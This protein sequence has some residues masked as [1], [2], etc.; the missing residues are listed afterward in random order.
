M[1]P[2]NFRVVNIETSEDK[3][4]KP[5]KRLKC[6]LLRIE[7]YDGFTDNDG[8]PC[9]LRVDGLCTAEE[10]EFDFNISGVFFCIPRRNELLKELQE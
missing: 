1:I 2:P 4:K 10:P 6:H 3:F 9:P 8:K 7:S 5:Q